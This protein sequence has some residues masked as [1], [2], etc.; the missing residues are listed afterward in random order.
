MND[1]SEITPQLYVSSYLDQSSIDKL[2]T[3]NFK[4]IIS[5]IGATFPIEKLDAVN[6]QVLA[7][8]TRDNFL[9]PIPSSALNKGVEAALPVIEQGEKVLVYCQQGKRRSVTMAAAILIARG[10][11]SAEAMQ[12]IKSKRMIADPYRGYVKKRI[13]K[14]EKFFLENKE[15]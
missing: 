15:S 2:L 13:L 11:S 6:C 4:L 9:F 10:Y 7:L 14:F 5:M 8:K 3:E 12:M 1:I